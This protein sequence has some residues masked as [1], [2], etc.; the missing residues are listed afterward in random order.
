MTGLYS[1]DAVHPNPILPA[2]DPAPEPYTT[3][4]SVSVA[5]QD[6]KLRIASV[7]ASVRTAFA[8]ESMIQDSELF[9]T[10]NTARKKG[11]RV[12]GGSSTIE[13]KGITIDASISGGRVTGSMRAT[14]SGGLHHQRRHDRRAKR[15]TDW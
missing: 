7:Y 1:G 4:F 8:E 13:K 14:S 6:G 10:W 3:N 5:K 9:K 15:K 12:C 2:A 11:P